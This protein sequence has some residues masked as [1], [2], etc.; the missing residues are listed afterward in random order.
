L[1]PLLASELLVK[2]F[3]TLAAVNMLFFLQTFGYFAL[4]ELEP[5]LHLK[6]ATI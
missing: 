6:T 1:A 5:F 4:S 3:T 2:V